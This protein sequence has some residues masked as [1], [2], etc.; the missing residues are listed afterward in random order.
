MIRILFIGAFV[1]FSFLDMSAQNSRIILYRAGKPST[2]KY[3]MRASVMFNMQ[4]ADSLPAN[5]AFQFEVEG[6]NTYTVRCDIENYP[7]WPTEKLKISTINDDTTFV[8]ADIKKDAMG[9][10]AIKLKV[11]SRV[12]AQTDM[13]AVGNNI[14][15]VRED[16]DGNMISGNKPSEKVIRS[17]TGFLISKQGYIITNYHVTNDAKNITVR[18]LNGDKNTLSHAVVVATDK[19]NDL[20]ILKLNDTTAIADTIP[21][22]VKPV[23][24]DLGEKVMVFGYPYTTTMGYDIKLTTGIV[25][26]V[27]GYEGEANSYQLSAPVQPGNSGGPVFDEKG[28]LVGIVSAKHKLAESATYAVKSSYLANLLQTLSGYRAECETPSLWKLPMPDQAKV[29]QRLVYIIEIK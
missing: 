23:Q 24:C 27:N 8:R 5:H 9:N 12:E 18:N 15:Y 20:V 17:G 16:S 22:C 21:F 14:I 3:F 29:L 28:N 6:D 19:K 2:H 7:G 25:S 26:S 10:P 13:S 11:V 4:S 1:L